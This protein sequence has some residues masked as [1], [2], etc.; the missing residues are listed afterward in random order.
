MKK[1]TTL[2]VMILFVMAGCNRSAT[3]SDG[4]ITVDVTA[5]YPKKELILQD[6]LDV[7]YIPLETND[8]FLTSARIQAIGKDIMI[9]RNIRRDGDIFIFDRNGKG[10]R[11]INHYGQ[12]VGEYT[13]MQDIVPDEENDEMYVN[14]T[15]STILLVYDLL[16]NFKRSFRQKDDL[17][18]NQMADFDR[19]NLI[20]HDNYF[21][22]DHETLIDKKRNC[23]LIVSK[24]DGCIK[25]IPIPYDEEKKSTMLLGRDANGKIIDRSIRNRKLIPYQGSWILTEISADTIYRYSPDHTMTPFI[26]RTPSIQSMNPEVFLFTGVFTDRYYFMQTVKK[27]YNYVT[28]TGFPSIDLLYDRQENAIFECAVYNDDYTNKKPVNL[29]YE[30]SVTLINNHEIAFA[31]RLEAFELVEAYEKGQL[32]GKLKEIAAELDE[33]SNA[34]IMLAKHKATPATTTSPSTS[35]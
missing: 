15:F 19:D 14:N 7:E 10:L 12:G 6:F 11:K 30:T 20:C 5:N 25:E 21:H 31:E 35:R 3:Q 28:N 23:F 13:N 24:Q 17:L 22:F 4:F 18:L 29:V 1:V 2:S 9:F 27:V 16:G 26:V 33:E 32:K 34:V 8:E